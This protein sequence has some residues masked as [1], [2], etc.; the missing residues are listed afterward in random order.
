[1]KKARAFRVGRKRTLVR[2]KKCYLTKG[3]Y[4]GT[5]AGP[6]FLRA[7]K[8]LT[9]PVWPKALGIAN[10]HLIDPHQ[11][12]NY[13]TYKKQRKYPVFYQL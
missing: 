12:K 6:R 7:P 4:Q 11:Q 5:G 10:V 9:V 2:T 8:E 1:M 3:T 13:S